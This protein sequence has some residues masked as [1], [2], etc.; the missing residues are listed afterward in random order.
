[1]PFPPSHSTQALSIRNA[2]YASR[3]F[4]RVDFPALWTQDLESQAHAQCEGWLMSG[5]F[6]VPSRCVG[7]AHGSKT[8]S[9]AVSW[10]HT[11]LACIQRRKSCMSLCDELMQSSKTSQ[12]DTHLHFARTQ[13]ICVLRCCSVLMR[14]FLRR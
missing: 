10:N 4:Q 11:H 8:Q 7:D 6:I 13:G 9:P 14:C 1:M 2:G 3:N 12:T 5:E